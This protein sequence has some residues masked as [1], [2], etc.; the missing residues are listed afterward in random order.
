MCQ[1]DFLIIEPGVTIQ[2]RISFSFDMHTISLRIER[3]KTEEFFIKKRLFDD[4]VS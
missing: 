4:L 1:F 3:K 2:G